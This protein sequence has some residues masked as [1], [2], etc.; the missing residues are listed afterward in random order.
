VP[1]RHLHANGF[2]LAVD[3]D[4][5]RLSD[6]SIGPYLV[7]VCRETLLGSRA[8]SV[9]SAGRSPHVRRLL[10]EHTWRRIAQPPEHRVI[11]TLGPGA[12]RGPG[13]QVRRR[14]APARPVR[15][16]E[17]AYGTEPELG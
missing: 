4:W 2:V 6:A 13:P 7:V 17:P 3:G 16:P 10:V 9:G 8:P 1:A 11:A 12:G 14:S 5:H 15:H